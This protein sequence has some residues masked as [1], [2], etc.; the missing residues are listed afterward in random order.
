MAQYEKETHPPAAKALV[1]NRY[2]DDIAE[3]KSDV[4]VLVQIRNEV[5]DLVGRFGFEF[6][7]RLGND[8][9]VGTVVKEMKILGIR[10]YVESD[11]L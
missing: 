7:D 2:M 11:E 5:C 8:N 9:F 1:N 3:V 10:Y 4:R 6:K